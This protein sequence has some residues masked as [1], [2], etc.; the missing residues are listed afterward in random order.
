MVDDKRTRE[1]GEGEEEGNEGKSRY[2][3]ALGRNKIGE[4]FHY[5]L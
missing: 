1:R 2:I 5:F 3:N 4:G